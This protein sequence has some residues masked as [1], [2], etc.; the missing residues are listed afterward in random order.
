VNYQLF[1]SLN[2]AD[3]EQLLATYLEIGRSDADEMASSAAAAGI[4]ADYSLSS[5]P[6][7]LEWF[8]TML[9]IVEREADPTLPE[10]IRSS[11]TY[12]DG[13]FDFDE[14]SKALVLQGSYYFGESFVRSFNHLHWGVGKQDFIQEN[15]PVVAGFGDGMEM[16]PLLVVNNLFRRILIDSGRMS[17]IE[18][19]VDFW[20]SKAE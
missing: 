20:R 12:L 9:R 2:P 11:R 14:N 7:V 15:M 13:L 19:V 1:K 16:P 18:K 5:V 6:R 4:R 17:D 3:A 8:H 10:W